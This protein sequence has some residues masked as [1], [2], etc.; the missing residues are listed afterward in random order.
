MHDRTLFYGLLLQGFGTPEVESLRSYIQRL[1]LAHNFKPRVL[2]ELLI[3]KYPLRSSKLNYPDFLKAWRLHGNSDISSQILSRCELAT[4]TRLETSSL[5]RF[6]HILSD[7]Y[8]ARPGSG[9][10]C[11]V[12]LEMSDGLGYGR[13]LWEVDCV[14]ACPRHK[15]KLRKT[16][17]CGVEQGKRLPLNKRPMVLPVCSACGSVHFRCVDDRPEAATQAQVWVAENVESLLSLPIEVTN[18]MSLELLKSGLRDMVDKCYEGSVV[19]AALQSGLARGSVCWWL[20]G[21]SKPSLGLLVQLCLHAQADLVGLFSGIYLER[22]LS[23]GFELIIKRH[24]Q[25]RD[26]VWRDVGSKLEAALHESS[27]PTIAAMATRLGVNRRSMLE[28]YPRE[29][30]R[31]RAVGEEYRSQKNRQIYHDAIKKYEL[32]AEILRSE[33]RVVSRTTLQ[34]KSKLAAFRGSTCKI[35]A[36]DEVVKRYK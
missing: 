6:H 35:R 2:V 1:A 10:Y 3:D 31:L 29:V 26:D 14:E 21:H 32:C 30:A 16:V 33:G 18:K 23:G 25:R 22:R 24:Y 17:Q 20:Q 12:C 19:K 27:P 8:L 34:R 9:R 28:R 4:G 13:L 36:A 11:P 15:L 7:V 5:W